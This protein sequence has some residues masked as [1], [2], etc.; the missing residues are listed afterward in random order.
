MLLFWRTLRSGRRGSGPAPSHSSTTFYFLVFRTWIENKTTAF[1]SLWT[2]WKTAARSDQTAAARESFYCLE[3]LKLSEEEG[4]LRF[5]ERYTHVWAESEP[6]VAT[7]S[8]P[9]CRATSRWWLNNTSALRRSTRVKPSVH[10]D[11]LVQ[12]SDSNVHLHYFRQLH[13]DEKERF[14]PVGRVPARSFSDRSEANDSGAPVR[15][16]LCRTRPARVWFLRKHS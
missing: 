12:T 15:L 9:V 4:S 3:M 7:S 5:V 14:A 16:C 13:W 8:I 1:W 11:P 10:V 6:D 2:L